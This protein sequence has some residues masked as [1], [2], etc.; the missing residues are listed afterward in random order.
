MFIPLFLWLLLRFLYYV[1]LNMAD[2]LRLP[3]AL[4]GSYSL[5]ASD[6]FLFR[7]CFKN[8]LFYIIIMA[9][10]IS[11]FGVQPAIESSTSLQYYQ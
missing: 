10:P 6:T 8:A 1:V 4:L 3:Y 2:V 7:K 5:F 11:E 9:R